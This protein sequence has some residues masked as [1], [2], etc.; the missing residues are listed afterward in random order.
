MVFKV[1]KSPHIA[2]G[3]GNKHIIK[4]LRIDIDLVTR[5]LLLK[6]TGMGIFIKNFLTSAFKKLNL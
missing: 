2:K 5:M 1:S 4:F 6:V 3:Y